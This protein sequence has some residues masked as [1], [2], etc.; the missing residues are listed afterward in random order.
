MQDFNNYGISFDENRFCKPYLTIELL[1]SLFSKE[2]DE[3]L[4]VF[5]DVEENGLYSFKSHLACQ[6]DLEDFL[7]STTGRNYVSHKNILF[8]LVCDV[9]FIKDKYRYFK[10]YYLFI[11]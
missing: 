3:M 2:I 10:I 7:N 1:T 9:L 4:S 8:S 5:F 6:K 11:N